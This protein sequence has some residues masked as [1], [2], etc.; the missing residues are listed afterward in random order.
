[1]FIVSATALIFSSKAWALQNPA[2]QVLDVE[3]PVQ[4]T[5]SPQQCVALHEGQQ[6]F[7]EISIS[8]ASPSA[9]NYC[10]YSS[11]LA[12]PITCWNNSNQGSV[13]YNLETAK[14]VQFI[15][16]QVLTNQPNKLVAERELQV[17]WVY[18]KKQKSR[19]SW[20]LF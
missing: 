5:L 4:M 8:W 12:K 9:N 11:Q 3:E 16:M 7:A 14:N 1:M 20:R 15:L 2:N 18:K 17:S 13:E 19:L 10:L 6:C